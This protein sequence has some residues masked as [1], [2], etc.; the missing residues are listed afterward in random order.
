MAISLPVNFSCNTPVNQSPQ[1]SSSYSTTLVSF[2]FI[3]SLQTLSKYHI[4]FALSSSK[5]E[6][7]GGFEQRE[8]A[9]WLREEQRWLR[10]EQRWLREEIRWNAE[11]EALLREVQILQHQI[12]NAE[13]EALLREVQ[14]LQHQIQ[15]LKSW[16]SLPEAS[17]SSMT[18]HEVQLLEEVNDEG[19]ATNLNT[20]EAMPL[21]T[22]AAKENEEVVVKETVKDV[23]EE[24]IEAK[25]EILRKGSEGDD[26]RLMQEALLKL[27]FYC[28]EEEMEYSTFSTG[29][30]HAVKTWQA[31]FGAPEDG[32]MTSELLERLFVQQKIVNSNLR[33][34]G[35]PEQHVLES[36]KVCA[37]GAPIASIMG[38]SEFEQKVIKG[39]MET[40]V[41]QRRV[42]LL[43]ENQWEEPSSWL[44]GNTQSAATKSSSDMTTRKCLTC[45]GD[46]HL[47]CMDCYGTGEPNIEPQFMEWVGEGA[48]CPYC[49]GFG[50]VTCDVCEG[51]KVV[52]A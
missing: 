21:V 38:I 28:G 26:V 36:S 37:N 23:E 43:G 15:E 12:Q 6:G 49:E 25:R 2:P 39:D 42:F 32:I 5:I 20:A 7:S 13:R 17:V 41:T 9:R 35:N 1:S 52:N 48:K 14:I 45:H 34:K 19:S 40:D 31:S 22:E 46:G 44:K 51:K 10:E 8:E 50:F 30:E 11:R 4:C 29:T 16:S 24:A 33:L 3:P 47:I 27:G 18:P